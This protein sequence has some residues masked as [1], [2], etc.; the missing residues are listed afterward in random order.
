MEMV[1]LGKTG[2]RVSRLALGLGLRG[3]DDSAAAQQMIERAIDLGINFI[4]CANVY[5]PMDD[6][7]NIGQSERI[8]GEVLKKHR[9][10][11]VISSKVASAVG[12]GPK[13]GGVAGGRRSSLLNI[14]LEE[15]KL[16]KT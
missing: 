1:N 5:G 13:G 7:A 15:P 3:Q 11:L 10:D 6:R 16:K 4:D 14:T 2:L 8:L 9:D 12:K